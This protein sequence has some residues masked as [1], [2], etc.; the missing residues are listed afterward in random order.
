MLL[1]KGQIF[2]LDISH[3]TSIFKLKNSYYKGEQS[4]TENMPREFFGVK[5][6]SCML[7]NLNLT[8]NYPIFGHII[9]IYSMVPLNT[10]FLSSFSEHFWIQEKFGH[11]P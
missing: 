2:S 6:V 9:L 5:S 1:T 10:S 11:Q 8:L 4:S 7:S 3:T